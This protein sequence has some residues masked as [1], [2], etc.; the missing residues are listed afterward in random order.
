MHQGLSFLRLSKKKSADLVLRDDDVSIVDHLES[1]SRGLAVDGAAERAGGAKD[2]LDGA[3]K[4]ARHRAL[5]HLA[6]DV[7][8][9]I[10]GDV[11]IVLDVLD[12]LAVA[13]R[14]AE[15]LHKEGRRRGDD[16]GGGLAVHDGELDGHVLA[17]PVHGGLLDV[18][19]DLLRGETERTDLRGKS[20]SGADLTTDGAEDEYFGGSLDG[21]GPM[22]NVD[23]KEVCTVAV[24]GGG[25]GG[26]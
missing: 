21:G 20:R 11:A 13:H 10:E 22:M 1:V 4:L 8:H 3:L 18:L 17:L 23:V 7:D 14:L 5:A 2:L 16:L 15:A 6:R 12:L 25:G 24:G 9:L 19:T 26:Q